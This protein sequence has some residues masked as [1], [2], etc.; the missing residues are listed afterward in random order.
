MALI[1]EDGT[2]K[3]DATSYVSVSDL[4]GF[5]TARGITMS[6]V[7]A[8]CEALLLQAMDF[9]LTKR[10]KWKGE[11][12]TSTQALDWPRWGA[13]N[14]YYRGDI[15]PST[16]IPVDLKN[17]QM[18]LACEAV[19]ANLQPNETPDT[20]GQIVR[21]KVGPIEVAY[22]NPV[23]PHGRIPYWSKSEAFL[24]CLLKNNGMVAV[25]T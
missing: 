3:A 10:G 7:D 9:L 17:A 2:A 23:S 24:S 14:V 11:R 12:S 8:D 21:K 6:A 20:P 15:F 13:T 18:A 4:R 5:A 25:R 16:S 22:A 1:V 19:S